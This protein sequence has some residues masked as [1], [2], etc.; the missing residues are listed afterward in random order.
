MYADDP[1]YASKRLNNTLVRLLNGDLFHVYRVAASDIGAIGVSGTNYISG[2]KM[3][4]PLDDLD[5]EPIPLGFVNVDNN[6]VFTCRK[7]MRK[8]WRQGLSQNSLLTYGHISGH[9]LNFKLLVQPVTNQ[10]PC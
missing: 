8:D 1:D 9:D 3:W 5:L 6:M 10:Y 2:N 7:P 4:V